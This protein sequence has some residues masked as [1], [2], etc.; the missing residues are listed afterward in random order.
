[1]KL[2]FDFFPI[3]AF[4]ITYKYKMPAIIEG[5]PIPS[6]GIVTAV[7]AATA[8]LIAAT[9]LQVAYTY[10]RHNKIEK[11]HVI[12]VVIA[13]VFGGATI[14]FRNPD[15]LVWKVSIAMWLF[16]IVFLLS[17]FIWKQPL[18]KKMMGHQ[19]SMP[20][21]QWKKLN[22]MWVIFYV[23]IGIINKIVADVYGIPL[24]VEFK[25]FGLL[26]LNIL[27]VIITFIYIAK[28][29]VITEDKIPAEI[30]ATPVDITENKEG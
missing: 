21:P 2:L 14:I 13:L 26:G 9:I 7:I 15:F 20:L 11:L 1:M 12:T 19:I 30:A 25:M 16:A 17:N 8:I 23:F 28:H 18:L 10:F 29:G 6:E 4:Y 5:Q 3:I 24:W 22:L 27:L